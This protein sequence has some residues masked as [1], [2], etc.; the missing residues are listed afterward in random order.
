V[1]APAT[2]EAEETP[3]RR[4]DAPAPTARWSPHPI[5][6]SDPPNGLPGRANELAVSRTD[7]D[8]GVV[9]RKAVPLAL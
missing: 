4:P 2:P 6:P 7:P 5:T 3:P 1:P 8:A 9:A